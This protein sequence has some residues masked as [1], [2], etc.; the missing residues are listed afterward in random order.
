MCF[1]WFGD[2]YFG[3]A[4]EKFNL[5]KNY[6]RGELKFLHKKKNS[7]EMKTESKVLFIWED[8]RKE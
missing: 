7:K 4:G 2:G 5:L 6:A 3:V 8:E 1:L